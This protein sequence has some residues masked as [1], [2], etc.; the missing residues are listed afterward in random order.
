MCCF[1][2]SIIIDPT[3]LLNCMQYV[4]GL[5]YK[6]FWTPVTCI[7]L[8]VGKLRVAGPSYVRV[9]ES[10]RIAIIHPNTS[11]RL[12]LWLMTCIR[13]GSRSPQADLWRC[14]CREVIVQFRYFMRF[15]SLLLFLFSVLLMYFWD[16]YIGVFYKTK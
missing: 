4:G 8:L 6:A 12:S 14:D 9:A 13:H 15:V 10:G 3:K 11:T 2:L 16:V 1:Y 7:S 5:L